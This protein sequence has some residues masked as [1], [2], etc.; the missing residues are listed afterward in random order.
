[1]S[2]VDYAVYTGIWTDWSYGKALGATLTLGRSDANL[3]IAF[4]AFFLTVVTS[5]L[6]AI[7]CFVFHSCLSSRGPR[8]TVHHQRQAVLRNNS[9]PVSTAWTLVQLGWAW[10]KSEKTT[11]KV[12]PLLA[13]SVLLAVG[14]TVAAGFSSRIGRNSEVL[15]ASGNCRNVGAISNETVQFDYYMPWVAKQIASAATYAQQCYSAGSSVARNC[16]NTNF[17][18]PQLP[19]SMNTTAGCPFDAQLCATNNSNL[20]LDTGLLDSHTH[21]GINSPPE[22]RFQLRTVLHCAP[23]VTEGHKQPFT[24]FHDQLFTS[25]FY[26]TQQGVAGDVEPIVFGAAPYN[27]SYTDPRAL[28]EFIPIPGLQRRDAETHLFFLSPNQVM[29]NAPTIDPWYNSS[30]SEELSF[31]IPV[32]SSSEKSERRLWLAAEAASPL[33]CASQMQ[34]CFSDLP[35]DQKCTPLSGF[36]DTSDAMKQLGVTN[37][38]TARFKWAWNTMVSADFAAIN[39][40]RTLGQQALTSRYNLIDGFQGGTLPQDQWQR[41]VQ[42]WNAVS[43]AT[44]Q[45]S[46]LVAAAGDLFDY[47]D[48][49]KS[50]GNDEARTLCASQKMI[51]PNHVSFSLF[52]LA[53]IAVFGLLAIIASL[54]LESVVHCI[55]RR[56]KRDPYTRMEWFATGALQMQR[57]AHEEL[58]VGV[59]SQCDELVP[60]SRGNTILAGLDVSDVRHPLLCGPR[61]AIEK[62]ISLE[63][64]QQESDSLDTRVEDGATGTAGSVMSFDSFVDERR[65]RQVDGHVISPDVVIRQS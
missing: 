65:S 8:D 53:F 16:R 48:A 14:F 38:S 7:A 35:A 28:A 11:R 9:G 51:S 25:Y 37:S 19:M 49:L 21:L 56:M 1:M 31:V 33:G 10:R 39:V 63:S 2:T 52:G 40:V 18:Q 45:Q 50:P 20:I 46:L 30:Q 5:R 15:L 41:D 32:G 6:W 29:F 13:C 34:I 27:G 4:V 42:Y 12:V 26:D 47:P 43:L 44:M 55:Q 24:S 61:P 54:C 23:L 57:M 36:G 3:L 60:V 17:V 64:D 59:W 58:G 22:S 62:M